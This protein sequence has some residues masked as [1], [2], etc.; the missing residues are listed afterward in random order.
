MFTD[1]CIAKIGNYRLTSSLPVEIGGKKAK[2]LFRD[3]RL[4]LMFSCWLFGT[5]NSKIPFHGTKRIN[6]RILSR[7]AY[8]YLQ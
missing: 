4:N 3:L 1:E 5:C 2:M 6:V 8:T 7:D